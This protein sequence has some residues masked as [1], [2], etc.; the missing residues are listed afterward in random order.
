LE[1]REIR[2][3]AAKIPPRLYKKRSCIVL[4]RRGVSRFGVEIVVGLRC[5]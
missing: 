1:K 2:T 4:G 3:Q 5:L